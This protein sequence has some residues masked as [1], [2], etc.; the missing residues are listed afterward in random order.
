MIFDC[1]HLLSSY[2]WVKSSIIPV[3]KSIISVVFF[4]PTDEI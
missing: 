2:S 1:L 3:D 4:I